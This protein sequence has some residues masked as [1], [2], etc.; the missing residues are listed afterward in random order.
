MIFGRDLARKVLSGSKTQTR[1]PADAS[2]CCYRVGHTYALQRH[3]TRA[4]MTQQELRRVD[5]GRARAPA[6]TTIGRI[7][8]TDIRL[9]QAGAI[10]LRDVIAEGFRATDEF[11]VAWVGVHDRRWQSLTDG[12]LGDL[13]LPEPDLFSDEILDRH[14][15]TERALR[16]RMRWLARAGA[17]ELVDGV[18]TRREYAEWTAS[19]KRFDKRHADKP[20]WVITF[21]L[22]LQEQP[23]LL[24]P[25]ARPLGSELGYVT[26]QRFDGENREIT[27]PDEP[28]AVHEQAQKEITSRAGMT[29]EQWKALEDAQRARDRELLGFERRLK[30]AHDDAARNRNS[31]KREMWILK[32]MLAEGRPEQALGRIQAVE[33]RALRDAA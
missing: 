13:D 26:G 27:L 12:L 2:P 3:K 14:G 8:V 24:A 30:T 15:L 31:I 25:A 7:L 1:R 29:F 22:D 17:V 4:E 23:R 33:R 28:E 19:L 6:R 32:Q 16:S 10:T 20:V 21:R 18:W 5:E 9:E 11:K